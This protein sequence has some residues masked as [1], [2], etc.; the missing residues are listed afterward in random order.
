M[1]G[2]FDPSPGNCIGN[3]RELT[4]IY[5]HQVP[6]P[7]FTALIQCETSLFSFTWVSSLF[8]KYFFLFFFSSQESF[9]DASLAKQ[10]EIQETDPTYEE[11]MVC[12][13]WDYVQLFS[14]YALT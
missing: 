9:D 3:N 7:A 11:K 4:T 10:K 2:I 8:Q 1:A 5:P 14:T 12:N 6:Q 13:I